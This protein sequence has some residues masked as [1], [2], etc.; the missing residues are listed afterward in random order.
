MM[1]TLLS[2]TERAGEVGNTD[3]GFIYNK[4]HFDSQF[5]LCSLILLVFC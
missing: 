1:C 3:A 5:I 2:R 4:N